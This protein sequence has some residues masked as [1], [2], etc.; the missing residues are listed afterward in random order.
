VDGEGFKQGVPISPT[1][2]N[3][4]VHVFTKYLIKS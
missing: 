4:V 1:L 3:L 2:F